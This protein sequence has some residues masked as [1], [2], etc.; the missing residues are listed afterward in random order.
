MPVPVRLERV[1]LENGQELVLAQFEKGGIAPEPDSPAPRV[2]HGFCL[3]ASIRVI[4]VNNSVWLGSEKGI[5]ADVSIP[6]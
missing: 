1:D 4:P 3:L 5:P 6:D 2:R